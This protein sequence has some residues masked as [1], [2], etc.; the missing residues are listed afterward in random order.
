MRYW[1]NATITGLAV[2]AGAVDVCRGELRYVLTDLSALGATDV[3]DI[4]EQGQVAGRLSGDA[5]FYDGNSMIGI[6]ALTYLAWPTSINESGE[7]VGWGNAEGGWHAFRY[8]GAEM[9]DLGTLGGN[10]SKA[11]DINDE[12][13]IVGQINGAEKNYGF[14]LQYGELTT[15]ELLA[16][17]RSYARAIN[18]GG[19]VV[20]E[21]D[22]AHEN[23][24]AFLY[25][26]TDLIDLGT[27]GGA[28]SYACDINER[29]QVVGTAECTDGRRHA[30]LWQDGAI[31]DLGTL[32]GESSFARAIN[33]LGVI[34]GVSDTAA[35]QRHAFVYDAATMVDLNDLILDADGWYIDDVSAI[36]SAGQIVGTSLLG[37]GP[38]TYLLTPTELVPEPTA[39]ALLAA[40]LATWG[41]ARRPRRRNENG[42]RRYRLCCCRVA[43]DSA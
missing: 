16:P 6:G 40:G 5:A 14:V 35:G 25:E 17:G 21:A 8:D 7:I 20:G 1:L 33:D 19:Q 22:F 28:T 18:N 30:T 23:R 2:L 34:V 32:G 11:H 42:K 12:G 31:S 39:L 9:H 26:G 27:L 10:F 36:N 13:D 41:A 15:F 43:S 38:R 29:G 4:N 24:R 37:G 3:S